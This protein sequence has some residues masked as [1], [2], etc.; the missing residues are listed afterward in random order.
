MRTL[1]WNDH[2]RVRVPLRWSAVS[3]LCLE[4]N[5]ELGTRAS[6][7]SKSFSKFP[8]QKSVPVADILYHLTEYPA[9]RPKISWAIQHILPERAVHLESRGR[10]SC[11]IIPIWRPVDWKILDMFPIFSILF[12]HFSSMPRFGSV[13]DFQPQLHRDHLACRLESGE[14]WAGA[15]KEGSRWTSSWWF[16]RG[17]QSTSIHYCERHGLLNM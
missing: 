13:D 17:S 15:A 12:H 3:F 6:R 9:P 8:F 1:L 2:Q 16:W 11:L 10:I 14:T 7:P 5:Y 4:G